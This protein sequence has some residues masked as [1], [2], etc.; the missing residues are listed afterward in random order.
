MQ[1][2]PANLSQTTKSDQKSTLGNIALREPFIC[3]YS[4]QATQNITYLN[5]FIF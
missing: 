3:K 1:N 5:S 4:M 2:A